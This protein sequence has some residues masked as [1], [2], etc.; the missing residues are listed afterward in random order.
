VWEYQTEG[1]TVF[2]FPVRWLRH[3][4]DE[5]QSFRFITYRAV[6]EGEIEEVRRNLLKANPDIQCRE[7]GVNYRC[8]S[9]QAPPPY[10]REVFIGRATATARMEQYGDAIVLICE[11]RE[12]V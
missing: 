3:D 10:G 11:W 9:E 12:R 8:D 2:G 5:D 6:L 4:I 1:L 7:A